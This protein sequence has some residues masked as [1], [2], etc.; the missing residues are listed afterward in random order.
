MRVS[1]PC[2]LLVAALVM[3]T[4]ACG[5][6][7]SGYQSLFIDT[8]IEN[9]SEWIEGRELDETET[10]SI[11]IRQGEYTP[12]ILRFKQEHTYK[13]R[14]INRDDVSRAFRAREFFNSIAVS[15]LT[16]GGK[17]I[18]SP[19]VASV[20]LGPYQTAELDFVAVRDGRYEFEDSPFIFDQLISGG[21]S[22][23]IVI[24]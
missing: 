7:Y 18:E 15:R 17:K 19:C 8:C 2:V 16:L 11:R 12:M 10:V 13:I 4:S 6:D 14:L 22:G 20:W 23:V 9:A 1:S 3:A 24:E 5:S 21:A